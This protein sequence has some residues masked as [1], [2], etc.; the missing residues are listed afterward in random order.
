MSRIVVIADIIGG[1]CARICGNSVIR[2]SIS[3]TRYSS[4]SLSWSTLSNI[5]NIDLI[6]QQSGTSKQ[7]FS[8]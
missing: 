6:D 8:Q 2:I 3:L 4:F 5:S 1:I 7:C